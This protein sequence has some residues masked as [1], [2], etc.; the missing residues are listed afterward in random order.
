MEEGGKAREQARGV[1]DR[2]A[3]GQK[4]AQVIREGV[5]CYLTLAICED[6]G[7]RNLA[8]LGKSHSLGLPVQAGQKCLQILL[9]TVFMRPVKA[10]GFPGPK[11]GVQT[12]VGQ[13]VLIQRLRYRE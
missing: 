10:Q 13:Q 4:L 12:G 11:T 9:R 5:G 7:S 1:A 8:N 3:G 6:T 2:E